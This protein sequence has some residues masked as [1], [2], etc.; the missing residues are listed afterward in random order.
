MPAS[1]D[2]ILPPI[3]AKHGI[4]MSTSQGRV[5][6]YQLYAQN[7]QVQREYTSEW[8][9]RRVTAPPIYN[10]VQTGQGIVP[11]NMRSG[12]MG[13]PSGY[14][15]PMPNEMITANQQIGTLK[16][17]LTQ[18]KSLYKDSYVG[19][20]KGRV[21]PLKEA[22]IGIDPEQSIFNSGIAQMSNT[23]V[24]LLSGKQI[25]EQE[26]ARLKKQMPDINLPPRNFQARMQEF[27]RTLNSIIENRTRL[28]GGY[29]STQSKSKSDPLG[30]R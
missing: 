15:K 18:V 26:Y 17:A 2:E 16:D 28:Q 20:I 19:P 14:D 11:S 3:V 22:T 5:A 25:N 10:F 7:P 23:L 8:N 9:R 1:L 29:G 27:E 12:Q 24:Y 30:I 6:G 4:D 13:S 21:A